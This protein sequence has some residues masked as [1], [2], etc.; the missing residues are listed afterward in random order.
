MKRFRYL[1]IGITA[2]CM[3]SFPVLSFA[4]NDLPQIIPVEQTSLS[5]PL[6]ND[7]KFVGFKMILPAGFD[8]EVAHRHQGDIFGY[9]LKGAV[10]MVMENNMPKTYSSG[11]I[12]HE[13]YRELHRSYRNPDTSHPAEVLMIFISPAI[14]SQETAN[15]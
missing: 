4:Q 2:C 12:F 13:K 14:E 3:L 1:A 9:V 10:E 8:N 15:N 6:L 5:T 7:V 11:E